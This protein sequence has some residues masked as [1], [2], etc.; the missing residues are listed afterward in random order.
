[1]NNAGVT[2]VRITPHVFI[3]PSELDVLVKAI[4]EIAATA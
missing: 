4:G 2:G 3:K 1:V